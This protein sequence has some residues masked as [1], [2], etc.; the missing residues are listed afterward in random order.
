MECLSEV[1]VLLHN[2]IDCNFTVYDPSLCTRTKDSSHDV[3]CSGYSNILTRLSN[4][5]SCLEECIPALEVRSYI[6]R[7][8][9]TKCSLCNRS[10]VE[11]AT[12][13]SL[14]CETLN[15]VLIVCSE[16]KC[17]VIHLRELAVSDAEIIDRQCVVRLHV[18]SGIVSVASEHV[19]SILTRSENVVKYLLNCVR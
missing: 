13:A 4:C 3:A 2:R 6:L 5:S 15:D 1:E 17:I 12:R 10:V 19:R 8:G 7:L 14:P 11:D 9:Y 18:L 16:L